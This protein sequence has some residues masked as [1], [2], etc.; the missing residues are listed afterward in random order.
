MKKIYMLGH[1]NYPLEEFIEM[2][3]REKISI[4]YDIRLM[5]F[6]RYVPQYNQTTLPQELE[7]H[8]IEYRY[9]KEL[10]PRVD[11]DE[12]LF[13]KDGFKYD[14]AVNRQRI[15]DGIKKID[16]EILETQNVV[17]MATKREPLECHR[18]L[19]LAPNF[20]KLGYEI[21]HILA[22]ET[23]EHSSCEIKL[24]ETMNRRIKRKTFAMSIEKSDL[25]NAYFA[26]AEKIAKIGMK[27]FKDLKRKVKDL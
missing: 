4:L 10:G 5:P 23:I 1:S 11:G 12:P 26:Q 22:S 2:L 27:K 16:N 20:K 19:V 21:Y 7:K 6:S 13:D 25:D 14:K 3:K 15:I 8:G 24:I 17:I 18:F 9:V